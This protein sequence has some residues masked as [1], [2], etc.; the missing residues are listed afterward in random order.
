M[1]HLRQGWSSK[2]LP[3][4]TPNRK[5]TTQKLFK[6]GKRRRM[7]WTAA[8]SSPTA[9][10]V[11]SF[12][13]SCDLISLQKP[14]YLLNRSA[15]SPYVQPLI[16]AGQHTQQS[17]TRDFL[18]LTPF[19]ICETIE[20]FETLSKEKSSPCDGLWGCGVWDTL[21]TLSVTSQR[22]ASTKRRLRRETFSLI[23]L[24]K[25]KCL[26]DLISIVRSLMFPFD[27][28]KWERSKRTDCYQPTPWW[29]WQEDFM[30]HRQAL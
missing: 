20:F 19:S 26:E 4:K 17:I 6:S 15:R 5:N 2:L 11:F 18:F 7:R 10:Y 29:L 30:I 14:F 25:W 24:G 23:F 8:P 22:A 12:I 21:D 1:S 13:N 28:A 9:I 27:G 3:L 16:I